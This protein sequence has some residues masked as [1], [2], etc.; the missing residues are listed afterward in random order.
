MTDATAPVLRVNVD[1][2]DLAG[3]RAGIAVWSRAYEANNVPVQLGDERVDV[4][5]ELAVVILRAGDAVWCRL[6]VVKGGGGHDAGVRRPPRPGPHATDRGD[7]VC[8]L[9][10]DR[11]PRG[12]C[13]AR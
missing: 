5:A 9:A 6:Q 13:R 1:C 2:S 7:V 10:S 3:W 4:A 12:R 11:Y 8:P